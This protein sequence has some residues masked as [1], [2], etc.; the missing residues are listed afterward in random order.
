[1][2][3][4]YERS[5]S[6]STLASLFVKEF[7]TSSSKADYNSN[8][9]ETRRLFFLTLIL[10]DENIYERL[11][12]QEKAEV[13]ATLL[14]R[15]DIAPEA[16]KTTKQLNSS[17][18]KTR[19]AAVVIAR[20]YLPISRSTTQIRTPGGRYV[21]AAKCRCREIIYY[22]NGTKEQT[23]YDEVPEWGKTYLKNQIYN[24]Y[25]VM[26]KREATVRYNCHS[27]AWYSQASTNQY[28]INNPYY[29]TID[30]SY[31]SVSRANAG[32]GDKMVYF[33]TQE[34]NNANMAHS[35]II[36]SYQD[37]GSG[38][39]FVV[40]SK[41]GLSGLY[42][43]SWDRCPYFFIQGESTPCGMRFYHKR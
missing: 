32:I 38:R 30:G 29:Y 39:K 4:L 13:K 15:S 11:S 34:I 9:G 5:K 14:P 8:N 27:Y 7:S 10:T 26:P 17:V 21:V 40:T 42:E 28:W 2:K 41:W 12:A 19:A 24:T 3:K 35:A 31:T 33:S 1:M 6:A 25:L 36:K 22:S 18:Q 16:S 20:K 43:H 37:S 23:D